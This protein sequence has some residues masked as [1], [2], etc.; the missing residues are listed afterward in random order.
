MIE[1]YL[2]LA[3]ATLLLL[4]PGALLARSA[5]GALVT[6]LALIFGAMLVVVATGSSLTLALW[7]LLAAGL[8]AIPVGF[9][10]GLP[11]VRDPM[12]LAVLGT[13]V[14]FGLLLWLVLP[15]PSGDALFHLARVRKLVAFDELS[16]EAVGEFVD[17]G[18]HPGYAFPLWHAFL[19][20]VAK[21]AG[22]DPADVVVHEAAVLAP[23][24]FLVV[25]EAGAAVFRSRWLGVA[26]LAG[27]VG[28][29]ALAS[30][31]GG[32]LRLLALPA[33]AG[34][35]MLLVP[36]AL[37][38]V[39]TYLHEPTRARLA[40]VAGAG[41]VLAVVHPTY[42]LFL[43][44]VLV[45]FAVVRAVIEPAELRTLL[46]AGAAFA[47]GAAVFLVWLLPVV[48]DTASF[49]PSGGQVQSKRHGFE[50]YPGQFIVESESSFHLNPE[51]LTRAGPVPLAALC[52][53]PLALFAVRRRWAAFVLGGT[54]VVLAVLLSDVLFPRLVDVVSLSQARRLAGFL[55]LAFALAG[56][57]AVLARV[58]SWAVVPLALAAGVALEWA[59]PGDFGYRLEKGGPT[60]PVWIA[61][62]G[63][64]GA[65]VL[66]L[67]LRSRLPT[68]A[69][70]DWLPAA[71]CVLFVVP[72][73]VTSGWER[74]QPHQE[75]TPE[76]RVALDLLVK[77]GDVVLSDPETSY[78]IAA[79]AP[80]YVAV[81]APT[82]VGDTKA[83]R[84]YERVEAWSEYVQTG[85]FPDRY[86]WVVLDGK[87]VRTTCAPKFLSGGRY[88]LCASTQRR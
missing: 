54:L 13:G 40:L 17:G 53:V 56:G 16:L 52:L 79:S 63:S 44:L 14:L 4:A 39:L 83:N 49:T 42:A 11:R 41:L 38:L 32:A 67:L 34:G 36:A 45:G 48:Q 51:V 31:S 69:R 19:A 81:S 26:T 70:A 12:W 1:L 74:P 64:L 71:A 27:T 58:L 80:V 59:W 46:L 15:D 28:V 25:Y 61:L 29:T 76:L 68:F 10:R 33:T 78:W 55:P 66:G 20:L 72:M 82:H 24:S 87:R 60:L 37:A 9:R 62:G 73:A 7:L 88:T 5:S 23:L 8:A 57:A 75:L 2:R 22:V 3:G 50:R 65:I 77:P 30:G 21:L 84:P 35:R 47:V 86:D 18:L 43:L 6:S 85:S